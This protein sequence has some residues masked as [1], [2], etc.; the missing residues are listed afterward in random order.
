[1][2]VGFS[3]RAPVTFDQSPGLYTQ[4]HKKE[5]DFFPVSSIIH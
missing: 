3:D 2:E 4:Y 5:K 1:M